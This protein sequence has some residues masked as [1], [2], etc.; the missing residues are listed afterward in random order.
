MSLVFVAK[1]YG[2]HT[3]EFVALTKR[4]KYN[5]QVR[6]FHK[7]RG[8]HCLFVFFSFETRT[9]YTYERERVIFIFKCYEKYKCSNVN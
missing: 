4:L 9:I 6:I 1:K 8:T 5:K 3:T 2:L 7:Y